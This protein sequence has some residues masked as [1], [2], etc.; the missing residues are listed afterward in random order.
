MPVAG[1]S[2]NENDEVTEGVVEPAAVVLVPAVGAAAGGP[3]QAPRAGAPARTAAAPGPFVTLLFS[4][5]EI[6]AADDCY[7][8]YQQIIQAIAA[9]PNITVTD[10]L[11]VGQRWGRVPPQPGTERAR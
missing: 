5:S 10:P 7:S 1:T 9:D 8:D 11:T 3:A 4:R 6:S 2:L